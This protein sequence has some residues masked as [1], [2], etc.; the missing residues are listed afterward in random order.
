MKK[1]NVLKS[2]RNRIVTVALL[3]FV[4]AF[5]LILAACG[6]SEYTDGTYTGRSTNDDTDAYGVVTITLK[7]NIV[8]ECTFLTYNSNGTVKDDT[9]GL[10]GSDDMYQ[11]AQLAVD[12]MKKY[13]RDFVGHIDPEDVETVTGATIAY[14]QFLEAVHDALNKAKK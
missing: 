2:K 14:N 12:A 4:L 5:G 10:G 7:D 6:D 11:K 8:S 3:V 1:T 9:Y 13:A